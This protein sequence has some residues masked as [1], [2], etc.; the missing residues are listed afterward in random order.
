MVRFGRV[1]TIKK[2]QEGSAGKQ[3]W[4]FHVHLYGMSRDDPLKVGKVRPSENDNL[5]SS[6]CRSARF[7]IRGA[8]ASNWGNYKEGG[9]ESRAEEGVTGA[10]ADE[11]RGGK[12]G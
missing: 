6:E 2:E 4:V 11:N 12:E 8:R 9:E 7:C 1:L 10:L 3:K 5:E